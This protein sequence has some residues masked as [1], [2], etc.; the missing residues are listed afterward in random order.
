MK[1]DRTQMNVGGCRWASEIVGERRG[2]R[3]VFDMSKICNALTASYNISGA[4]AS[5]KGSGG[6]RDDNA[7]GRTMDAGNPASP[8][9]PPPPPPALRT[10]PKR[11]TVHVPFLMRSA[12]VHWS[13]LTVVLKVIYHPLYSMNK[14]VTN[15]SKLPQDGAHVFPY[16][17]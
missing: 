6:S 12:S 17:G 11:P 7:D 16:M 3:I 14:F 8:A 1:G 13:S 5:A 4:S 2:S 10:F 9:Q 15:K